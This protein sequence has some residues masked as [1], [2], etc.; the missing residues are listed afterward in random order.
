MRSE[1]SSD[2]DLPESVTVLEN[3]DGGKVYLVGTAHF[4]ERSCRDVE[5]VRVA[6]TS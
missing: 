4:S 3:S 6:F 1:E 2:S 5:E